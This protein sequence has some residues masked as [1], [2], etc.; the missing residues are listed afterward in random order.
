MATLKREQIDGR[1]YRDLA[2]AQAE[3]GAFI[4]T[5]YNFDRLHSALGY[6]SPMQFEASHQEVLQQGVGDAARYGGS[7]PP[8]PMSPLEPAKNGVTLQIV[9]P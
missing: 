8:T 5:V 2:E 7:A 4:D 3:I 9:S 6:R 1:R